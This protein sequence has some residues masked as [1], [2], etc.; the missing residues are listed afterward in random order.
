MS[1]GEKKDGDVGQI[2]E[3]VR[4]ESG[5]AAVTNADE[6]SIDAQQTSR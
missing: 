3:E 1:E 6:K 2:E 4:T 5:E